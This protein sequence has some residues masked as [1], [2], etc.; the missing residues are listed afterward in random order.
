MIGRSDLRDV[1]VLCAAAI[2]KLAEADRDVEGRSPDD[3]KDEAIEAGYDVG[4]KATDTWPWA[5]SERPWPW[6]E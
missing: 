4:M 6:A 2:V 3:V 5:E 1:S